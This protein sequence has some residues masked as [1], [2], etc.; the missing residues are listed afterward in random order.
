MFAGMS[1]LGGG[2]EKKNKPTQNTNTIG[3]KAQVLAKI[4]HLPFIQYSD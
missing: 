3:T 2:D 1:L 4:S